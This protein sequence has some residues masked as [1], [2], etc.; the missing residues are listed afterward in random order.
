M[1]N[2]WF[3]NATDLQIIGLSVITGMLIYGL[4]YLFILRLSWKHI[5]KEIKH[6]EGK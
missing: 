1:I 3:R 4:I 5:D 2:E 6:R